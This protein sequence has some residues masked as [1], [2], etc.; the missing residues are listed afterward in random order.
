[1]NEIKHKEKN[2]VA[3][4]EFKGEGG[5]LYPAIEIKCLSHKMD[6][7]KFKREDGVEMLRKQCFC[8]GEVSRDLKKSLVQSFNLLQECNYSIRDLKYVFLKE[9]RESLDK[10]K[11]QEAWDEY[12][13]YLNSDKW[14]LKRK[15]VLERDNYLCQACLTNKAEE[16]HHL[17]YEN[18]YDEPL[19]QLIS[20]CKRCHDKIEA[21]K[22]NK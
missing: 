13:Q 18:I 9:V 11:N 1:M 15:K 14:K 5:Y 10:I 7:V 16:I 3:V 8:C 20:V 17:T 21:K 12:N 6:F 4:Y 22:Q 2:V 19:Y